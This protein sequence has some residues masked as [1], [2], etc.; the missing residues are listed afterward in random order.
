MLRYL[1]KK[2]INNLGLKILALLFAVILWMGVVNLDDPVISKVYTVAVT[3]ENENAVASAG[4][5]FEVINDSGNV[6]FSVSGK[7]SVL[8]KMSISDFK[9]TAD[10]SQLIQSDGES[11]VPI[12]ITCLRY[13]SQVTISKRV[14]MLIVSLED[15]MRKQFV[16]QADV[17]GTP[18]E[19]YTLGEMEVA[20]NLLKITGP[21]SEVSK[22]YNVEA[23]IDVNGMS[24]EI[25]DNVIP[26][27][28]DEDGNVIDTTRLTMNLNTVT[29][30]AEI[31]SEKTVE[32]KA[33]YSGIPKDGYE[34]VGITV[35]P[36]QITIKGR[37]EILNAI[38]AITIPADV[39]NAAGAD[40]Q[41]HQQVDLKKYL[42]D[43]VEISSDSRSSVTVLVDVEKLASREFIVSTDQID[44]DNLLEGYLIE[45]NSRTVDIRVFGLQSDL[46]KLTL[47]DIRPIL[48]VSGM[49]PGSHV[50]QLSV[51][52]D[53]N[54][55]I[56]DASVS[57]IILTDEEALDE[58]DGEEDEQENPDDGSEPD[59][60]QGDTE[61]GDGG[62]A[63]TET[64]NSDNDIDDTENTGL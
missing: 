64:D 49:A 40:G 45:Y 13:S 28:L 50:G 29:V 21:K 61:E 30:K 43:G 38:N 55:I 20:P 35:D 18:A 27:L 23:T 26:T 1:A 63:D 41:F 8:D 34:V 56:G 9:A 17:E 33:N 3:L 15:L 24:S 53:G 14:Q 51:T 46:D 4:K 44:V 42:P 62:E 19:G 59:D 39:I 22:I 2:L 57:Y 58:T 10:M 25:T 60:V 5:Y 16:I 54:F 12:E 7:R 52:L 48:D 47:S 36:A 37:S 32:V 31:L 11:T 6:T